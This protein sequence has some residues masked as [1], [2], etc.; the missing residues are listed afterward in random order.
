MNM[1]KKIAVIRTKL[2][3][4]LFTL[5]EYEG[6]VLLVSK[7]KEE[8]NVTNE[9][10]FWDT[11]RTEIEA[12]RGE[13]SAFNLTGNPLKVDLTV[14]TTVMERK[15][16]KEETLWSI[17]LNFARE[18]IN[19]YNEDVDKETDDMVVCV[20]DGE[21]DAHTIMLASFQTGGNFVRTLAFA[22]G[23]TTESVLKSDL[24]RLLDCHIQN[25][26]IESHKVDTQVLCLHKLFNYNPDKHYQNIGSVQM[27]SSWDTL[28]YD[29][30]EH[31][32]VIKLILQVIVGHESSTIHSMFQELQFIQYCLDQLSN[33]KTLENVTLSPENVESDHLYQSIG[34]IIRTVHVI[35]LQV[36]SKD[37]F[38]DFDKDNN[39]TDKLWNIFKRCGNI[40]DLSNC[41]QKLFE[42]IVDE[43]IKLQILEDDRNSMLG[44]MLYDICSGRATR[45]PHL[46]PKQ[47]LES[48]I[49][50]GLHKLKR[51][52]FK[53][54]TSVDFQ[55]AK[56]LQDKWK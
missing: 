21:D 10:S 37:N 26:G 41:F 1:Y 49:E 6:E 14:D 16:N 50:L 38:F 45:I 25:V 47:C 36:L 12:S 42:I 29:I 17:S 48:L 9:C 52:Y 19:D 55:I 51:N 56:D 46:S 31:G 4:F 5:L 24:N 15:E 32:A 34:D 2:H 44:E 35:N 40:N 23:C 43:S 22:D 18:F 54:I 3:S 39:L 8:G 13:V 28:Q 30:P 27:E 20:C 7:N 53:I 33:N 11:T